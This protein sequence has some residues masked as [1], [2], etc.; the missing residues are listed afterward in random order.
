MLKAG[1]LALRRAEPR[2]FDAVVALQHAAYARNRELLGVEPLP[3]MVDYETIFREYE[4]WVTAEGAIEGV[5]ILERRPEDLLI[6]SVAADT[7][8]Q[9][10]GIG[11]GLLA[12]AECRARDLGLDT[13]RLYTGAVLQ[14]LIDWYGRRGYALERI[15]ELSDRQLAHMVKRI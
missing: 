11:R 8:R 3:L 5:L 4:V 2:D 14:H 15:E 1:H 9:N 10:S 13:I 6:W 7:S 12:A